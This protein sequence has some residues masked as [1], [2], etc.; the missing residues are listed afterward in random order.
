M[1]PNGLYSQAWS[2][3]MPLKVAILEDNAERQAAMQAWLSDRLYMYEHFFFDEA[4]PMNAWLKANLSE[5]LLISLD[6]DLDLKP[7]GDGRWL[8]P[9]TGR[10]V[11]DHLATNDPACP[12]IIH[13]TNRQAVI[14][15]EQVLL[16][17]GWQVETVAP[18]GDLVWVA[19]AWWPMVKRLLTF[20]RG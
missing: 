11:A 6:H 1:E 2:N 15:M 8:D 13:S 9:G 14:G 20:N 17:R 12:L 19:E 4:A 10:D 7:G 18:Y 3:F 16:E 5:T